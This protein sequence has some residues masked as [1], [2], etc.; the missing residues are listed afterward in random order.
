[1]ASGIGSGTVTVTLDGS[2]PAALELEGSIR[3]SADGNELF[4]LPVRLAVET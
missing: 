4:R 2:A 1:M 3:V